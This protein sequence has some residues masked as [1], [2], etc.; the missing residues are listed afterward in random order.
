MSYRMN[1]NIVVS[2]TCTLCFLLGG[3]SSTFNE[4]YVMDPIRFTTTISSLSEI[5]IPENLKEKIQLYQDF[6]VLL[7]PAGERLYDDWKDDEWNQLSIVN[8]DGE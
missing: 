6:Q 5:K 3:V 7:I 2:L 4:S 8:D 1:F